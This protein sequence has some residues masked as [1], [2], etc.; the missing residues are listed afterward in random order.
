MYDSDLRVVWKRVGN[1]LKMF[2]FHL[3]TVKI[4]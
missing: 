1:D 3:K 2:E 4:N